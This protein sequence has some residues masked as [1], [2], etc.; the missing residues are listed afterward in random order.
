[1]AWTRRGKRYMGEWCGVATA[2]LLLLSIG[3]LYTRLSSERRS[4]DSDDASPTDPL[5]LDSDSDSDSDS[6]PLLRTTPTTEDR[7]DELDLVDYDPNLSN[8][9]ELLRGLDSEGDD[10]FDSSTLLSSSSRYYFDHLSLAIRHSFHRPSIDDFDRLAWDDSANAFHPPYHL[11]TKLTFASD[12]LPVDDL[13][14]SKLI[15]L[16]GLED[17]LLLK[18]GSRV[19][20]LRHGWGPWFD[21][22]TDFLRKDKMFKSNLELLNPLHNLLL[23]DPDA[24]GAVTSL[25]R[26]DKIVHKAFLTQLKKPLRLEDSSAGHPKVKQANRRTLDGGATDDKQMKI[27]LGALLKDTDKMDKTL[28]S[29]GGGLQKQKWGYF[30]GLPPYLSFSNFMDSFLRKSKCSMRV[31]MV[32]NSP[33][34]TFTIRHQ[35]GLESLLHHH[36]QA[37]VV[38][39]SET[40]ELDFFKD[41][42][43]DS[44]KVAVAMPNLEELLHDTPTSIFSSVWHEWR[45]TRFYSLHYSELIRLAA[46]YKYGGMYLDCDMV[47]LKPISSFSNSVG[48]EEPSPESPLNGAAMAFT[49]HS[50]FLMQCM[51]EFYSTY[52]DTLKRWN[53]A[54]LLTRVA[55]N[56]SRKATD[57]DK[58]QELKVQPASVF[59]PIS[60]FDIQRYFF[61]PLNDSEKVHQDALFKKIFNESYTFH[62]WNSLTS[63]LVPEPD[64]LVAR[65]LNHFCTR[66]SD[67]L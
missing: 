47:V 20:P 34:W 14:R 1:M 9:E 32:W 64:S 46:L 24:L 23:Q 40:I 61:S 66:C 21:A 36:P 67:V 58:H 13:V 35:R 30:P 63:A 5:L 22:K 65:I 15:T 7:I 10:V 49:K 43:K 8:E 2:L 41:F 55:G 51:S 33:S 16:N 38:L 26:G 4:W 42:V 56:F 25:T 54:E 29:V 31:F 11:P 17:A 45:R 50:S 18:F 39:F 28:P 44:F 60:S 27:S 37:C 6:D 3:L 48:M 59:F 53:G 62:F 52:D 57:A 19:S 12:D